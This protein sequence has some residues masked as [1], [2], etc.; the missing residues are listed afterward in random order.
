MGLFCLQRRAL[1]R[2]VSCDPEKRH[3][4]ENFKRDPQNGTAKET[5]KKRTAKETHKKVSCDPDQTFLWVSFAVLFCMSL[6]QV[7]S[8][9]RRGLC[10]YS[11]AYSISFYFYSIYRHDVLRVRRREHRQAPCRFVSHDIDRSLL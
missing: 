7:S 1:R 8:H 11:F 10:L 5:H 3:A 4:K 2:T 6:L 9:M